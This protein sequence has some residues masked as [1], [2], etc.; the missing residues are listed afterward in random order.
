MSNQSH[1]NDIFLLQSKTRA[2]KAKPNHKKIGAMRAAGPS[3]GPASQWAQTSAN[4][5]QKAWKAVEH[6]LVAIFAMEKRKARPNRQ[7]AD[8]L[9]VM[10]WAG[11]GLYP[12]IWMETDI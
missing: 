7:S 8:Q 3:W 11:I 5:P 10:L 6:V 1:Y 12:T 2:R 9:S 4:I